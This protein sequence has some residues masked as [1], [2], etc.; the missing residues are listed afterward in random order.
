MVSSADLAAGARSGMAGR[1]IE[2]LYVP[3]PRPMRVRGRGQRQGMIRKGG[4]RFSD[5]DHAQMQRRRAA[6]DPISTNGTLV[7][8]GKT[9]GEDALLGMQAVFRLVQ[10]PPL[11]PTH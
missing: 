6:H 5:K 7:S 3:L 2:T 4:G 1:D 8:V 11:E 10:T 9:P